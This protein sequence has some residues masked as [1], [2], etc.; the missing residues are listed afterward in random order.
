MMLP[1]PMVSVFWRFVRLCEGE[2][3][4]QGLMPPCTC[5][6]NHALEFMAPK[7]SL[8]TIL[9]TFTRGPSLLPIPYVIRIVVRLVLNQAL[10]TR[11]VLAHARKVLCVPRARR[12]VNINLV[13]VVVARIRERYLWEVTLST[14]VWSAAWWRR[15]R[16]RTRHHRPRRITVTVLWTHVVALVAMIVNRTALA[17]WRPMPQL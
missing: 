7:I 9:A 12:S 14:N 8:T 2:K 13:F 10:A 16:D 1:P 4:I 3:I 17:D 15:Q 5:M 6:S 11:R